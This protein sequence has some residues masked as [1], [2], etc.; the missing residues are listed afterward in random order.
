MINFLVMVVSFIFVSF[1][2][3]SGDYGPAAYDALIG[4]YFGARA[5][6]D[7]AKEEKEEE[8]AVDD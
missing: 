3:H 1:G 8:D 7:Y 5:L 4:L 6:I 2:I